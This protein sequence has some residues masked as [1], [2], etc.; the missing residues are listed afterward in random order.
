MNECEAI[1]LEIAQGWIQMKGVN[2]L[3]QLQMVSGDDDV[4]IAPKSPQRWAT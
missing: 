4:R 1:N 2:L 3:Y